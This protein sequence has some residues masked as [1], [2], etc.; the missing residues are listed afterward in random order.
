MKIN[1]RG[2]KQ[3]ITDAMK[4]YCNEKLS[5]LNKYLEKDLEVTSTVLF[6]I[7]GTNHKVEITIPLKDVTLRV[8]EEASDYYAA[9][10]SAID[11]L[12]R[13]IRKNKTKLENKKTSL[14]RSFIFED[15]IEEENDEKIIKRKKAQ[16]KPMDEDE[17]VLQMEL[18]GHD[19][20]LYK[21][22]D[23]NNYAVIYKRKNKGY[24]KIEIE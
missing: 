18:L 17:A 5:K 11:K 24:G 19:F 6:K 10:D 22:V 4:N 13:Q 21:D 16:A 8:E 12:E 14:G 9:I 23:I 7:N 1:I 2:E 20:F 3:E 15:L